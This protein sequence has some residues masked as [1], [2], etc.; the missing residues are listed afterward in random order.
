MDKKNLGRLNSKKRNLEE[1]VQACSSRHGRQI[2]SMDRRPKGSQCT[3]YLKQ[4][5]SLTLVVMKN[6]V[7]PQDD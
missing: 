4:H 3:S 1:G 7:L 6:L 5:R 2:G